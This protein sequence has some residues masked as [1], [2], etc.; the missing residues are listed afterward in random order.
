MNTC[1]VHS[2]HVRSSS[3]H[4]SYAAYHMQHTIQ[5]Q[6][7]DS[8]PS[9][10]TP[11]ILIEATIQDIVDLRRAN[12]THAKTQQ[13]QRR[14]KRTQ[15]GGQREPNRK[16]TLMLGSRLLAQA[17]RRWRTCTAGALREAACLLLRTTARLDSGMHGS[18]LNCDYVIRTKSASCFERE[19]SSLVLGQKTILV[20]TD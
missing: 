12:P 11:S 8:S 13:Q 4:A 5:S 1:N 6:R 20:A 15:H 7:R 19:H 2:A 18:V 9:I 14:R 10:Y 17:G 16:S 3:A